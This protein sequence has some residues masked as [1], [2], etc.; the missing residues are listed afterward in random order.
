MIY[1]YNT[2]QTYRQFEQRLL[3]LEKIF[4]SI[5]V[6]TSKVQY[7]I[8]QVINRV[9]AMNLSNADG[10]RAKWDHRCRKDSW[11]LKMWSALKQNQSQKE[12]RTSKFLP[13]ELSSSSGSHIENYFDCWVLGI[14]LQLNLPNNVKTQI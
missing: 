3:C 6:S 11:Q 9:A 13:E 1:I 12:I 4:K 5:L 14:V 10:F 8:K 7:L 2:G